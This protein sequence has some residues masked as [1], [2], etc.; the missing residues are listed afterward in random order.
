MLERRLRPATVHVFAKNKPARAFYE[1]FGFRQVDAWWDVK[2]TGRLTSC[3]ASYGPGAAGPT[4]ETL[5]LRSALPNLLARQPQPLLGRSNGVRMV[6]FSSAAVE[7]K[8]IGI[9]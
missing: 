6:R 2:G 8:A 7:F 9:S 5:R 4:H 3:Y 1:R